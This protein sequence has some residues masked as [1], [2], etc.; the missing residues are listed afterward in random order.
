MSQLPLWKVVVIML[1]MA[2]PFVL[3]ALKN[4]FNIGLAA[5]FVCLFS[6]KLGGVYLVVVMSAIFC[7][8]LVFSEHKQIAE[9][10]NT[11]NPHETKDH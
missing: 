7:G 9:T 8:Y 2:A 4:R 1:A 11:R 5:L 10:K 6:S 3:A